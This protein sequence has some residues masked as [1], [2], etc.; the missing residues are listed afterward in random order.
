MPAGRRGRKVVPRPPVEGGGAQDSVANSLKFRT[1]KKKLHSQTN[2][3]SHFM[4]GPERGA[5]FL[6]PKGFTLHG[7]RTDL[8][9]LF[10][11]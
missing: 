2:L 7:Y 1:N 5:N 8:F 4:E 9:K 3:K 10:G 6:G 11:N